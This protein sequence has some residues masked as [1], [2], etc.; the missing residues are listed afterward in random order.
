MLLHR[1][2]G[3]VTSTEVPVLP[4]RRLERSVTLDYAAFVGLARF[5]RGNSSTVQRDP[6]PT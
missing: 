1:V 3:L 6:L 5:E 2:R 4:V